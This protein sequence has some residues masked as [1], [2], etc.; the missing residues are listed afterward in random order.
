[1]SNI[2]L[3]AKFLCEFFFQTKAFRLY[4]G[5][6]ISWQVDDQGHEFMQRYI[7]ENGPYPGT[8]ENPIIWPMLSNKLAQNQ[9]TTCT[10]IPLS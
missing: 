1:M 5:P 2:D 4:F 3:V 6:Y 10:I 9:A 8:A 7:P